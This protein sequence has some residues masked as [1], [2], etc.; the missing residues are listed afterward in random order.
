MLAC[1]ASMS[2]TVEATKS[3]YNTFFSSYGKMESPMEMLLH[4]VVISIAMFILL[5][6]MVKQSNDK[7]ATWSMLV[8]SFSLFYMLVWGHKMPSL[9]INPTLSSGK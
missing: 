1:D 9:N 3:L 8:G 2:C 5:R 7:A 6:F 4:S